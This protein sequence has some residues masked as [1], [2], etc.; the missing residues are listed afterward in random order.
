MVA[1]DNHKSYHAEPIITEDTTSQVEK[2]ILGRIRIKAWDDVER[3]VRPTVDPFEFK[4]KLLLEQD[5]SKKSLAE[6]YEEV[7]CWQNKRE[8]VFTFMNL[9]LGNFKCGIEES[10]EWEKSEGKTENQ[11]E[12]WNYERHEAVESG[13]R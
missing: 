1:R 7:S 11:V 12:Q 3:K 10:G 8:Y 6:I 4:K 13:G 5:K 9:A 2:I